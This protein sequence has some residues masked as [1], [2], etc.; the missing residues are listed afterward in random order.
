MPRCKRYTHL[1]TNCCVADDKNAKA[2]KCDILKSQI[3]KKIAS[4]ISLKILKCRQGIVMYN[5][6]TWIHV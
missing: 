4:D 5:T 2:F 1:Y 6:F 3:K